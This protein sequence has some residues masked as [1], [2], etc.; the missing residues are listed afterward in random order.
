M[1]RVDA[2]SG[3]TNPACQHRLAGHT[4]MT[5]ENALGYLQSRLQRLEQRLGLVASALLAGLLLLGMACVYTTPQTTVQHNGA[6]YAA[7]SEDPFNFSDGNAF[8]H[9]ILSPLL[10]YL[11]F[12]RGP[13]FI[14]F[15]LLVAVLFLAAIYHY[16]RTHG[17]EESE[18]FLVAAL[19]AFSSPVLFLLRF[20]G[21]TDNLGYLLLWYCF[22]YRQKRWLWAPLFSLALFNHDSNVFSAPWVMLLV[23]EST[24][25]RTRPVVGKSSLPIGPWA[26]DVLALIASIIPFVIFRLQVKLSTQMVSPSL[27]WALL[28][29]VYW[30]IAK[31]VWLGVFEAFKLFWVIPL[32]AF[33]SPRA[34]RRSFDRFLLTSF[35]LAG[36]LQ[37]LI[38]HDVS[39]HMGHAFML[40]LY[41]AIL[42]KRQYPLPGELAR[43]LVVLIAYNFLVPQYYV[44]QREAYLFVPLP[45][46]LLLQAILQVSPDA[47]RSPW[48]L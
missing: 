15:P 1:V 7:I 48:R 38:A 31:Y 44:G 13:N 5:V 10:G 33:I 42:L 46:S 39:R 18:S 2:R 40:I 43:Y 16:F 24:Y 41:G 25:D 14:F 19:M 37:L 22:V 27:Y 20:Q 28:G 21:Y 29:Q 30:I 26:L 36:G 11:L 3:L 8:R 34:D 32:R 12:L 23:F 9:R 6:Y 4:P 35:F 17:F 47:L 45:I